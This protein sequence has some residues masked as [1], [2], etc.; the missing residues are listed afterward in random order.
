[1]VGQL[2]TLAPVSVRSQSLAKLIL[3]SFIND[4]GDQNITVSLIS[5]FV[6]TRDHLVVCFTVAP[7]ND[8]HAIK[9]DRSAVT[10]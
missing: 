6:C 4:H 3:T 10:P 5:L 1:M 8:S 2:R 7:H 9:S